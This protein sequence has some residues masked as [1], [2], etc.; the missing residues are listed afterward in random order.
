MAVVSKTREQLPSFKRTRL[1][2]IS[3]MSRCCW[4]E[5]IIGLG[6]GMLLGLNF[7]W[8]NGFSRKGNFNCIKIETFFFN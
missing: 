5:A 1:S 8:R 2:V 4:V 7:N 6:L 3:L